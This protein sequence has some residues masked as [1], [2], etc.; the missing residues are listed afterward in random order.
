[1]ERSDWD[2]DDLEPAAPLPAH[3]RM[4]RHPSEI[5]A[6]TWARTEPPIALGRALTATTG[7]VG[8]LLA[9]AIVLALL[10][11]R[12]GQPYVS[13][14]SVVSVLPSPGDADPPSPATTFEGRPDDSTPS[15]PTTAPLGPA[16]LLTPP[17]Y[18]VANDPMAAIA[19]SIGDLVITTATAAVG[20]DTVEL[21][22]ADG[23][24]S[25]ALVL[26][27][28]PDR[29]LALLAPHRSVRLPSFSLA[30][31]ARPGDE[32]TIGDGSSVTAVLLDGGGLMSTSPL[33][34][35]HEGTPLL[36][37]H[38]DLVALLTHGA[39]GPRVVLVD[40]L[41]DLRWA[42]LHLDGRAGSQL[43]LALDG[44]RTPT[45]RIATVQPDG[46]ASRAGLLPGDVIVAVNGR[47]V[48]HCDSLIAALAER[49]PGDT[50][51]LTVRRDGERLTATVV[52]D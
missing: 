36:D 43:G 7:A 42:L 45:M 28:D 39:D 3:E 35:L 52:T 8:V 46:P 21:A 18:H 11:T 40:V 22:L 9:G 4:W 29:G 47:K 50:V 23:S 6:E 26:A 51:V 15:A 33:E 24:T 19:V 41:D 49:R 17:T 25:D 12:A 2:D 16:A 48:H 31:A 32:L 20:H 5:G 13:A 30:G 37:R 38:G 1:M 10:P 27:V 14:R 44:S 34:S